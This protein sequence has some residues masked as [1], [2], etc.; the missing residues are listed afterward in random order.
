LFKNPI[1][2]FWVYTTDNPK[3]LNAQQLQE[4]YYK[5]DDY[6]FKYDDTYPTI[7]G[8]QAY[9]QARY[10]L[11]VIEDYYIPYAGKVYKLEFEFNFDPNDKKSEEIKNLIGQILSTFKFTN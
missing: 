10:D 2:H 1:G 7:A 3:K 11:G 8:V 6:G 9:K 4:E 5:N